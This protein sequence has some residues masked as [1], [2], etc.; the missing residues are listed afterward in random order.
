Q[1]RLPVDDPRQWR[2][3]AAARRL[4]CRRLV[5]ADLLA[6]SDGPPGSDLARRRRRRVRLDRG[7]PG[8]PGRAA[9]PQELDRPNA[10]GLR[11][12]RM[13]PNGLGIYEHFGSKSARVAM[14]PGSS[15]TVDLLNLDRVQFAATQKGGTGQTEGSSRSFEKASPPSAVVRSWNLRR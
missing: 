5:V 12:S 8:V 10:P 15:R 3:L 13:G 7:A 14:M 4:A 11:S 6:G 1:Q 2:I 9:A